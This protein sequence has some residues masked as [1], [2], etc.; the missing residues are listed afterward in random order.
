MYRKVV[1]A[2]D[3]SEPSAHALQHAAKLAKIMNSEKI[4]IL[5][6]TK[7]L[8]L[9]EPI[10]NIDLDQLFADEDQEVLAPAIQFLSESGIVYETHTFHG[11][12]ANVIVAYATEHDYDVII[13]GNTGKGIIKEALLG[14]VSHRV[15]HAAQCPVIIVK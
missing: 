12:P 9:Q 4:T 10:F 15:A 2:L 8:P 3:G 5:H 7:N 14:S 13:M 6:V 1:V 11:D